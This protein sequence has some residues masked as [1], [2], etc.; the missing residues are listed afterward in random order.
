MA[1]ATNRIIWA[2]LVASLFVYGAVAFVV[3]ASR[4][5][6]EAPSPRLLAALLGV[7]ALTTGLATIMIRGRM[8]VVPIARGELDPRSP[9]GGQRAFVP[10]ILCLALTESIGLY[11]LVLSLLAGNARWS[12]PFLAVALA[13]MLV[14]RPTAPELRSPQSGASAH[15][16][17]TPIG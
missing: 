2:A 15:L 9:S 14:H 8:L 7:V 10:Y 6:A 13:L 3:A 1:T 12:L 4:P 17:A 11:G 16:D 5:P